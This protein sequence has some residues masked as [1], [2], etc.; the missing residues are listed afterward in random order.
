MLT[1]A[2]EHYRRQQRISA[3]GLVAARRQWKRNPRTVAATV[4][5]FQI[6]AAR[7]AAAAVPLMLE[8]QDISAEPVAEVDPLSVAGV[9]SD[10][11]P[12]DTLLDQAETDYQLGLMVATQIQDAARV[13]SSL[14][15]ASRP[16]VTGWVR[17]M[18]PPSCS[19]CAVLAGKWFKWNQGF[20]RHPKCDCRHIPAQEADY[21][22][23]R[24]SGD[25]W[26]HTLPTADEL[27]AKY[28]NLTVKMRNE[29]GI[30]SQEDI[31]TKAGA[32]AIRDGADL[33][34]VV[35][36]RR[37]MQRAQ[38]FGRDAFTT[39]EGTTKR[40]L[41]GTSEAAKAAGYAGRNVG[42]RGAVK[43]YMERRTRRARLMPETIY[44]I[45]DDRADAIRLLKSYGYLI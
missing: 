25:K 33:N 12:L 37:G 16:G 18:N 6:L 42:Q 34:Q 20:E 10:G 36:A 43:N 3:T 40:G 38:L 41:Y 21:S 27:G 19:R 11:R 8:E 5:A 31:F 2:L 35:N 30:Y 32:Q 39:L 9:A 13:A 45:A 29:A 15:I 26:F 4:A 23:V 7:D 28:P 44:Q 24:L 1:S 22:D 14:A 17:M